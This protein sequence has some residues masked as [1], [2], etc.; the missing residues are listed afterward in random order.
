MSTMERYPC[1]ARLVNQ[2]PTTL[3]QCLRLRPAIHA[4]RGNIMQLDQASHEQL[5]RWEQDLAA[6]YAAFQTAKLNLDLTRGNPSDGQLDLSNAL[7]GMLA[8]NYAAP[9]GTDTRNYGGLDGLRELKAL[10]AQVL[11]VKPEETLIG[12]NSSLT[13]MHQVMTFAHFFGLRKPD[14]AWSRQGETK[15]ICLVPGYDRHFT[16]CRH[17]GITMIPVALNNDG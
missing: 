3:L 2:Y 9:D 1:L 15:F 14:D 6:Q 13:L 11:G 16:V 7:D 5:L 8:G 17:L 12:G 4:V 10:Y